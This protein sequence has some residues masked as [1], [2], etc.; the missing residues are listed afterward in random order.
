MPTNRRSDLALDIHIATHTSLPV[1]ISGTPHDTLQ[2]AMAI[3]SAGGTG[4]RGAVLAAPAANA[5]LVPV[6]N[7]G[8]PH[9]DSPRVMLLRDIETLTE[10]EQEWLVETV[11]ARCR[12]AAPP[13]WR[14]ITTTSVPLATRVTA[15][16][17]AARLFYLL[18]AIHIIV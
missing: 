7:D 10:S 14:L 9:C 8:A 5:R 12:T 1:L 11:L 3:A 18:N 6:M 17:F 13:E 15:G 2:V 16:A 4:G